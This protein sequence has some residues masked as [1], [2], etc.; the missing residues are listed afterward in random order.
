MLTTPTNSR[1]SYLYANV[2]KNGT[3][4]TDSHSFTDMSIMIQKSFKTL[5]YTNKTSRTNSL[6]TEPFNSSTK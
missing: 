6:T 4:N 1:T 3:N 2:V 5:K